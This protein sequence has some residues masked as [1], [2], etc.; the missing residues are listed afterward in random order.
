M[1]RLIGDWAGFA[2]NDDTPNL[3]LSSTLAWAGSPMCAENWRLN[4]PH[5]IQ[6]VGVYRS[7]RAHFALVISAGLVSN[8]SPDTHA[9]D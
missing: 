6:A 3:A 7:D 5:F 8:W 2:A 1:Q 4:L 9:S